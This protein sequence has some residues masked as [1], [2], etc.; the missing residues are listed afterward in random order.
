MTV[1]IPV[2]S[3]RLGVQLNK[4]I[5]QDFSDINFVLSSI[6]YVNFITVC[7]TVGNC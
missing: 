3:Q 5:F 7:F 6:V 1:L 2:P 4:S